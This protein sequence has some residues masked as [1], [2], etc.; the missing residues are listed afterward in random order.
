MIRE[1]IEKITRKEELSLQESREVMEEIMEGKATAA[2]TGSLLT[3]LKMKGETSDEITGC[4]EVMLEKAV[5]IS[6]RCNNIVDTCG[7]GGDKTGTFNISTAASFVAAGAGLVVA[8]HGNR[9]V[10][11]KSGSA[12]VLEALG[13]KIDLDPKEVEIVLNKTGMGFLYAPHFHQA[14]RYA[15]GPRKEIG[16]RSI[17]NILGPLTNPAQAKYQLIGV[18]DPALVEVVAEVLMKLGI[19]RA[20]V[21]HGAGG[22]DEISTLGPTKAAHLLGDKIDI[23]EIH[24]EDYGFPRRKLSD[25]KGGDA[26]QNANIILNVLSGKPGPCSEIVI[27]NAAA[28]VTAAGISA[29]LQEGVGIAKESIYSGK[30]YEKL[31]EQ[32][33]LTNEIKKKGNVS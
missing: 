15:I 27:L 18:Y 3:G 7:T 16:V 9:S 13:V 6:S 29:T 2:Q 14:M 17:F 22:L 5:S 24:P 32:I 21:V 31:E 20:Y 23:L 25:I 1:A 4:A 11:S 30:A 8:K 19:K 10:S 26:A 28:A 33:K 12:D